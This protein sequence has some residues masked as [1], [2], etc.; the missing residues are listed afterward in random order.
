[1][2]VDMK[3]FVILNDLIVAL[4]NSQARGCVGLAHTLPVTLKWESLC[5][6]TQTWQHPAANHKQSTDPKHAQR[7]DDSQ[8]GNSQGE[9]E[10]GFN[11]GVFV[12]S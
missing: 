10:E 9:I 7:D 6:N 8:S 2:T 5:V 11:R 12:Y 3:N 1:V 4:L